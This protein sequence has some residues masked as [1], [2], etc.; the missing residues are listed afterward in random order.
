MGSCH[1]LSEFLTD[2]EWPIDSRTTNS[3]KYI[4]FISIHPPFQAI[5]MTLMNSFKK[6]RK[7][8]FL[9]NQSIGKC[10]LLDVEVAV[11]VVESRRFEHSNLR[12][13]WEEEGK[14]VPEVSGTNVESW[15]EERSSW[16]TVLLDLSRQ[17]WHDQHEKN[18]SR[19]LSVRKTG[20]KAEMG[21]FPSPSPYHGRHN[22]QRRDSWSFALQRSP[23]PAHILI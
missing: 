6:K 3:L 14:S 4:T 23:V 22:I 8:I 2:E 1:S 21:F 20:N 10:L 15:R 5:L 9:T 7:K 19:Q 11:F 12:N 18:N 13:N 17:G 16:V